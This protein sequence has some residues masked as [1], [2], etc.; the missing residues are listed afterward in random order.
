MFLRSAITKASSRIKMRKRGLTKP[1]TDEL[2]PPG[3]MPSTNTPLCYTNQPKLSRTMPLSE[4]R[5]RR[6]ASDVNY[7]QRVSTDKLFCGPHITTFLIF[8]LTPVIMPVHNRLCKRI[9]ASF[10]D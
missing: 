6:A 2:Y 3:K 5:E 9:L 1:L 4:P 10:V 8:R 7:A